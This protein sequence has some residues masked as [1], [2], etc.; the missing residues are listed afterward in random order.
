MKLATFST[1]DN[2]TPRLGVVVGDNIVDLAGLG[3][4]AE[5]GEPGADGPTMVLSTSKDAVK[6]EGLGGPLVSHLLRPCRRRA[7]AGGQGRAVPIQLGRVL[8]SAV[9]GVQG[10]HGSD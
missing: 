2:S 8:R 4:P 1:T 3:G 9:R 7:G 10:P 6:L 5:P